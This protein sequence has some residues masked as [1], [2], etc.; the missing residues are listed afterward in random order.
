MSPEPVYGAQ[1]VELLAGKRL[2]LACTI[3]DQVRPDQAPQPVTNALA[4]DPDDV[5]H[6]ADAIAGTTACG[7][8]ANLWRWVVP[9]V[10]ERKVDEVEP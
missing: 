3:R 8:N 2:C 4:I 9:T 10:A 1:A 5:V 7:R 6:T